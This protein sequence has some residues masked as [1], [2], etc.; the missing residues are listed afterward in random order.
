MVDSLRSFWQRISDGI[1]VQLLWTQFTREAGDSYAVYSKEVDSRLPEGHSRWARFLEVVRILFWAM[2][3]KLSPARRVLLLLSVFILAI[4]LLTFRYQG[5]IFWGGVGLLILLALELADRVMMK[6]DLEIA[7][8]IQNWMMPATPPAVPGVDIAFQSRAANTV[9]GD[10]YDVFFRSGDSVQGSAGSERLLLIVADVA[11]KSVPAA[12]LMATLQ[13]SLRALAGLPISLLELVERL[14]Q[15]ACIQNVGGR[16]F[17]TAF[18]AELEPADGRLTYVNAG[19]NWPVLRRAGGTLERLEIGGLPLGLMPLARYQCGSTSLAADDVLL[20]FSD[21]LAEA[22]DDNE[23]E[24]GEPRMLAL[25]DDSCGK[26]AA[27]TLAQLL[28]SLDSFVGPV[29]QHDDITCMVVR[30]SPAP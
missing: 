26:S 21:G 20:V 14:N 7:S 1:E 2:I 15:Y 19:H 9:G 4:P 17:S 27:D 29:R 3:L 10:Y 12:L 24:F 11:G 6:R 28:Q 30:M 5:L 18:V 16:R 22:E 23:Q 13:A 25:M 8:E